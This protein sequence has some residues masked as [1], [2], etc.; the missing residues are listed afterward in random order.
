MGSVHAAVVRAKQSRAAE[1]AAL[2][3]LP[4]DSKAPFYEHTFEYRYVVLSAPRVAFGVL[5]QQ[6]RTTVAG[7][8]LPLPV[9]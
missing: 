8:L 6:P 5:K 3:S 7:F 1:S 9:K 2:E 4:E